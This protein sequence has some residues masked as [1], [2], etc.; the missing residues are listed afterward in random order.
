MSERLAAIDIGTNTVLLLIAEASENGDLYPVYQAQGVARLGKGVDKT[1]QLNPENMEKALRILGE[2]KTIIAQYGVSRVLI[3]GTSALRDAVNR[4]EFLSRVK[5]LLGWEIRVI[6][7]EEE[8]RLSFL[9][10]LS[11]KAHLKGRILVVDIGG[12]STEF[13]WG[14]RLSLEGRKSLNIGSVRLS[15]RFFKHDPPSPDEMKRLTEYVGTSLK[16]LQADV[17]MPDHC[18]GVAG[19]VTTLAAMTLRQ[20]EYDSQAIDGFHLT[21]R[22]VLALIRKMQAM[23]AK[24]RLKLPGL[25]PGR[26]DVILAGS[27][28]LVGIMKTFRQD[29]VIVSDRG[30]RFGLILDDLRAHGK[31]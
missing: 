2:Y 26:E 21:S 25:Y 10:A 28:L 30:L 3:A 22:Q 9:G 27:I 12:G 7:G 14:N 4:D 31:K 13:V 15:E 8:A 6:T 16:S 19:T 18:V 5:E 11:N 29:E 24:E 1:G 20:T 17:P 23:P